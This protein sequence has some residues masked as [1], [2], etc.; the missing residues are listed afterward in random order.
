LVANDE[1]ATN[2]FSEEYSGRDDMATLAMNTYHLLGAGGPE[3]GDTV[4]R[5]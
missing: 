2:R 1:K 4:Q 5:A 3:C